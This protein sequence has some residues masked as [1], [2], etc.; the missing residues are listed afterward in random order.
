MSLKSTLWL[1]LIALSFLYSAASFTEVAQ[2]QAPAPSTLPPKAA[3]DNSDEITIRGDTVTTIGEIC[4]ADQNVMVESNGETLYADHVVFDRTTRFATA[5]GNARLYNGKT[6]YRGDHMTY[7]FITK[8]IT[9]NSFTSQEYP[10]IIRG[11]SVIT[12]EDN[13]YRI[14]HGIMTTDDRETPGFHLNAT[15]VEYR[16]GDE[17]VLKNVVVYVGKI[18]VFYVPFI[19]QS[20]KDDRPTYTFDIGQSSTFGF[21][22]YNDFNFI[23]DKNLKANVQLDLREN[24]GVGAGLNLTYR[25]PSNL[26]DVLNFKSYFIRDSYYNHTDPLFPTARYQGTITSTG[27]YDGV[28]NEDRYRFALQNNLS[29]GPDFYTIANVTILSDPYVTRDFFPGE[30]SLN[31]QP[32]SVAELGHYSPNYNLDLLIRGRTNTFFESVDRLPELDFDIKQQP[33]FGTG[34][35][36]HS[37]SSVAYLDRRF[38]QAA[39][40][41][42]PIDDPFYAL[43]NPNAP[44][45]NNY[46][47]WRYDTYHEISYPKQYFNFLSLTPRVGG[48]FT[49][50]GYENEQTSQNPTA[51]NSNTAGS[52]VPNDPNLDPRARITGNVGLE[53][54]FKVS[55]TWDDVRWAPLGIN[56]IRHVMEPFFNAQYMPSP[57]VAPDKIRPFDA[58]LLSDQLQPLN[59]PDYNSVDS[60]NKQEVVRLGV[61]NRIQ[62][63]RDGSNVNLFDL[64]TYLDADFDHNFSS[65]SGH[66][67]SDLY[68]NFTFNPT[69]NLTYFVRSALG[70]DG[71]FN[72]VLQGVTFSPDPSLSVTV[73][74]NYIDGSPL[75]QNSDQTNLNFQYR[76]NEHWQFIANEQFELANGRLQ[77]QSYTV[78]RDL[79][80]WDAALTY[81]SQE[82]YLGRYNNTVYLTMTL[83]ALPQ[84]S[85]HSPGTPIGQ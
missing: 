14:F 74:Q 45:Q 47:G 20:L 33:I 58:R 78:H 70:F 30:Y 1:R 10:K 67:F 63:R 35:Q 50:Y 53:G 42:F 64:S 39:D 83:K 44:I 40:F 52:I 73:G 5:T 61:D 31:A 37:E 71:G 6:V 21:F 2:A 43:N 56:G 38:A 51:N 55:K 17:V 66:T 16:P 23:I 75:F 28:G 85:L 13:H 84:R 80:T 49:Y 57:N 18:P 34:L 19:V 79:E 81:T 11:S 8:A 29:L 46:S 22:F 3:P 59:F 69:Q 60:I 15:Q 7:N 65:S 77:E 4:N 12:V 76:L 24:R 25:S 82:E 27:V 72:E 26:L 68:N 9:A 41:R 32:D 54:D 62:T 36:Y 48:R